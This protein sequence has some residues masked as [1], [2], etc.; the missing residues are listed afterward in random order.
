ML[1]KRMFSSYTFIRLQIRMNDIDINIRHFLGFNLKR[2]K[3]KAN[4]IN[5]KA[6]FQHIFFS[7]SFHSDFKVHSK[8]GRFS[9]LNLKIFFI[10][11][12]V[13]IVG[14]MANCLR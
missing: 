3:F 1:S 8:F 9:V 10:T 11:N 13:A 6:P 12:I 2:F 5:S 7:K 4:L 14:A